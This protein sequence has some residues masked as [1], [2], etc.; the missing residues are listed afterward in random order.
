VPVRED[1]DPEKGK[2]R[3]INPK[4]VRYFA[5]WRNQ[6]KGSG[7]NPTCTSPRQPKEGG[8]KKINRKS[9]LSNYSAPGKGKGKNGLATRSSLKSK[10]EREKKGE[11]PGPSCSLEDGKKR[12][13]KVVHF[14]QEE[15]VENSY[16]PGREE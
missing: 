5:W 4:K 10:R 8:G 15:K 1:K 2:N 16:H 11:R 3:R 6:R 9:P 13:S 7:E 12:G 14:L